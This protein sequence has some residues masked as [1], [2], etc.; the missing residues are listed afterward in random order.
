LDHLVLASPHPLVTRAEIAEHTGVVLS[1]GG[2][3]VGRGTRNW[4]GRLGPDQ[5]LELIGPDPEQPKPPG[6]R[7]FGVDDV[8]D[9]TLV[10]WC[11]RDDDLDDLRA[12]AAVAGIGLGAPFAM[13]R[14]APAGRLRWR[15]SLPGRRALDAT[16]CRSSRARS[17]NPLTRPGY[18]S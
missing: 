16:V 9:A 12:R 8:T 6:P 15:V 17:P 3:H 4:L 10:T 11:A 13:E 14:D 5:Y 7:P 1:A 2:A 18:R